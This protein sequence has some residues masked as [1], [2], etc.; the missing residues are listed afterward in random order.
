[1]TVLEG[2]SEDLSIVRALPERRKVNDAH[3]CPPAPLQ[4]LN[5][6]SRYVLVY[7]QRKTA[8]HSVA[9]LGTFALGLFPKLFVFNE[10]SF[11]LFL[12][13]VVVSQSGVDL[14]QGQGAR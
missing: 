1:M 8:R 2:I 11:D 14:T 13:V 4:R 6:R 9:G 10:G 12:V 3:H 7:K 5:K